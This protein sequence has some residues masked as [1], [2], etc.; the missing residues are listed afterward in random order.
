M[1]YLIIG[2]GPCGLVIAKYMKDA[3][4][5]YDQV[6]ADKEIGGNW[7]HGVYK[8]VFT[9]ADKSTLEYPFYPMPNSFPHFLSAPQMLE[10]YQSFAD[11][12][13]LRKDITTETRVEWVQALEN[14]KWRVYFEKTEPVIYDGI[15]VCN[16]HHWDMRFPELPGNFEGELMHSKQYKIPEQLQDKRVLVIGSRN[17]A[18]DIACEAARSAKSSFLSIRES[19]WFIP[20]AFMGL[21]LSHMAKNTPQFMKPYLM[22]LLVRITFGKYS[23]YKLSK[24]NHQPLQK[25]PTMTEE[26][27]YYLRHGRVG[28]KPAVQNIHGK[29]VTF[30]DGT[31]EEIDLI[32]AAT[33]YHLTF[34]FLPP[35]LARTDNQNLKCLGYT[36]Y[37]DVKGLFFFGWPQVIGGIGELSSMM[38]DGVIN[39]IQLEETT[40]LPSGKILKTMG[41]KVSNTHTPMAYQIKK[42]VK[43]HP[44]EKMMKA[45]KKIKEKTHQN[46]PTHPWTPPS[47]GTQRRIF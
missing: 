9:D 44:F 35:E 3:Q 36:V 26:L 32:V 33:G 16:G 20:K 41:D 23:N 14:N 42:W 28:M 34:P 8:N 27:P 18:V 37:E 22:K 19:P 2:A 38:A 4:I 1:K 40:G 6:E 24:P 7:Y 29:T 15:I 13:D 30:S 43:Q 46:Q 21:P 17:S 5:A 47:K 11:A 10:Y 45:A 25:L 12:F 39:L 31:S